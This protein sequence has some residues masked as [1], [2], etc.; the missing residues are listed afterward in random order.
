MSNAPVQLLLT[1]GAGASCQS[2]FIQQLSQALAVKQIKVTLFNF[3]YMQAQQAGGT[4]RPPPKIAVLQEELTQ[5][6]LKLSGNG[7]VCFVAG[8]S[9]GGR[10]ASHLLADPALKGRLGGA[11]AYG[12]PFHPPKKTQWRTAHFATLHGCLTIIQG[13]RDPFG[14]RDELLE[15]CWPKV[16]LHWLSTADHDF[17]PLK[18]SGLTQTVLIEQAAELTRRSID[19]ILAKN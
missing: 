5:A 9:M 10:V 16:N 7:E 12:Y 19:A 6:L 15:L 1:H 3:A 17:K 14:T 4:R 2:A 8:K 13:E 11:F 18:R